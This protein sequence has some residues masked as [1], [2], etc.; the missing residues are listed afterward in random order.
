MGGIWISVVFMLALSAGVFAAT[1]RL[2]KGVPKRRLQVA[3][4]C[5]VGLLIVFV[6]V[7]R[8]GALVVM[9][10][11]CASVVVLGEWLPPLAGVLA[12]MAWRLV[13]DPW[14]RKA[15][16]V[17]P[18]VAVSIYSAYSPLLGAPPRCADVW[19][20]TV[21]RQTTQ[22]T[23][24]AAAAATLLKACGIETT[25]AEMA[26]LCL[27]RPTGTFLH[28]LYRGLTI[29]SRNT[30]LKA[31][32]AS[33]SIDELRALERP[34]ILTVMLEPGADVDPRY[35]SQW[36]WR[37]GVGHTVVLFGFNGDGTIDVGD[38]GVGREKWSEDALRDLWH[39]EVV[40]LVPR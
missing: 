16:G 18:L 19:V 22:S 12:G 36:G 15:T 7:L 24:S 8:G 4:V 39:G 6:Y 26:G 40:G 28:G 23:C 34:V 25:E 11:P 5:T 37:P 35:Q 3:A 31:E 30:G 38:P 17:V 33:L 9:L 2:A 13:P 21:C 14:W 27:S 10:I 1:V 32:V 29:R 20:G